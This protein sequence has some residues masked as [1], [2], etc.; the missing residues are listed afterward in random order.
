[1]KH[2][3]TSLLI[4]LLFSS[5]TQNENELSSTQNKTANSRSTRTSSTIHKGIYINDFLHDGILGDTI[6]EDALLAWC[7]TNGF[8]NIY[9][10]NIGA[11]LSGSSKQFLDPFVQ[12]AHNYQNGIDVTFVSAGFGTSFSNIESYHDQYSNLPKG[13]VS[14]IEFWNGGMNYTSDYLPWIHKLNSLKF[15]IPNGQSTPRNPNIIKRFYIG[16]IKNSGQAPS[17]TI[18]KELVTH[19][20]EILLANYHSNAYNLSTSTSTNSI[21]NRLRLLAL[22]GNELNKTVN[23]VILFNVNQNS[24]SPHI[25]SYFDINNGNHN[26]EDT[27]TNFY[28]DFLV[29]QDIPYKQ[30]LNLK[31]FGIYRYSDAKSARP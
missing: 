13:I 23:I 11:I 4:V 15:D 12:K 9:L 2:L 24:S 21:K 3:I 18:A 27:Y 31:G 30:F 14:E 19:H 17:L 20:D 26:F 22:A 10:Y 5:C 28:N 8:N 7:H 1:M 16:K 25:W 29:A 6:K